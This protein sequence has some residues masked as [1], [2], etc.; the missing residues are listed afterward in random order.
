L[1]VIDSV[2]LYVTSQN[3]FSPS[4]LLRDSGGHFAKARHSLLCNLQSQL[5]QPC[6][7]MEHH[8]RSGN[9]DVALGSLV[10]PVWWLATLHGA[11]GL[12]LDDHYGPFQPRPFCDS[13]TAAR[14]AVC[15]GVCTA[16]FALA[17]S[18]R[19]VF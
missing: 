8:I 12:Q 6:C 10:C 2:T 9:R 7:H 11:V 18:F 14:A 4:S 15:V 13:M 17:L 16:C 5:H 19:I 3:L 1:P